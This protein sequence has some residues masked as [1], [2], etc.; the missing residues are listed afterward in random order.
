ML[1]A[2]LMTVDIVPAAL[3]WYVARANHADQA[4]SFQVRFSIP[5]LGRRAFQ[6]LGFG[7]FLFLESLDLIRDPGPR[8][9]TAQAQAA[10]W[11]ERGGCEGAERRKE[12]Q[13]QQIGRTINVKD[14]W[15][16]SSTNET[17]ELFIS[18]PYFWERRVHDVQ[19]PEIL[20]SILNLAVL[21][22][23]TGIGVF[24]WWFRFRGF[25]FFSGKLPKT[26]SSENQTSY[27]EVRKWLWNLILNYLKSILAAADLRWGRPVI[28]FWRKNPGQIFLGSKIC[29]HFWQTRRMRLLLFGKRSKRLTIRALV[30]P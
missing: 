23:G 24:I 2:Y 21:M 13:H 25:C 29:P 20:G 6:L 3:L 15:G 27:S 18:R 7:I 4:F 16:L 10:H 28:L 1:T 30:L 14:I 26:K 8:L 11:R 5:R 17:A 12:A 19:I 9:V 22:V